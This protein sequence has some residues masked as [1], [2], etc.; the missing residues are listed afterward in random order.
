MVIVKAYL[1]GVP[2]CL[3]LDAMPHVGDYLEMQGRRCFVTEVC[4]SRTKTIR[5]SGN[6][7]YADLPD[8]HTRFIVVH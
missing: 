1:S 2:D 8:C 7:Y 4:D 3:A 6:P 5:L